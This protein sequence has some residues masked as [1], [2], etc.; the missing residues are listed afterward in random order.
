MTS[1]RYD[2]AFDAVL[3]PPSEACHIARRAGSS[4]PPPK[5]IDSN[6]NAAGE[7]RVGHRN[8]NRPTTKPSKSSW[9]ARFE[10]FAADR[11]DDAGIAGWKTS[12]LEARLRRFIGLWKLRKSGERWLDAGCGAGTYTRLLRAQGIQVVGIDYS[13]P[14]IL[15]ARARSEPDIAYVIADVRRL[16]LRPQSF[17]G[18]LCF[19]VMQALGDAAPAIGE[20]AIQTAPAGQLWVDALNRWCVVHAWELLRRSFS[21]KPIHLRYDSPRVI[22]QIMVSHGLR[23]VT[24]H[25]MPIVP[26]RWPRLQRMV[27]GTGC[28]MDFQERPARGPDLLSRVHRLRRETRRTARMIEHHLRGMS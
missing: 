19:G 1:A 28:S 16:P 7:T 2:T 22:R 4:H 12:G 6:P 24:I 13:L 5:P 10:E 26:A 9:R 23:N 8:D 11:D 20:L 25:W 21:G 15:K 17:D 14:T 18:V 27:E 3:G